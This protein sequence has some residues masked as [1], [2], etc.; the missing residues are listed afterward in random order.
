METVDAGLELVKV[1]RGKLGKMTSGLS[2]AL[3][4]RVMRLKKKSAASLQ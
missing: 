1:V 4:N 3:V 2:Y